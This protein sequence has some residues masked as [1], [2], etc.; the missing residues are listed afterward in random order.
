MTYKKRIGTRDFTFSKVNLLCSEMWMQIAE[1][2]ES[3]GDIP[4]RIEEAGTDFAGELLDAGTSREKIRAKQNYNRK[5]REIREEAKRDA[6]EAEKL[7]FEIIKELLD[8]N[9]YEYDDDWWK[10]NASDDDIDDIL[11][12]V[13][14]GKDKKKVTESST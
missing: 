12:E 6:A 2:L 1:K 9:N 5:K 7:R 10:K 8:L 3:Y 11:L 4:A 14:R 13:V